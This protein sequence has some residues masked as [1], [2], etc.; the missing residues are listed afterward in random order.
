MCVFH[1]VAM[2]AT[3][4]SF[5]AASVSIVSKTSSRMTSDTYVGCPFTLKV[6]HAPSPPAQASASASA[7]S[8]T[9]S[10]PALSTTMSTLRA[11]TITFMALSASSCSR[12]LALSAKAAST[13]LAARA[14]LAAPSPSLGQM[15]RSIRFP[16][17]LSMTNKR[18]W[19]LF[20]SRSS[21]KSAAANAFT[22]GA[23]DD[24]AD[25]HAA[26][27]FFFCSANGSCRWSGA[28]ASKYPVA[29]SMRL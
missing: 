3:A 12:L 13:A 29:C 10:N 20:A 11:F 14:L 5:D 25:A 16:H 8:V 26:S 15:L 22:R 19:S 18:S 2:A 7:R 6:T 24:M 27:P 23:S 21:P 17:R 9:S 1:R 4:S 28:L